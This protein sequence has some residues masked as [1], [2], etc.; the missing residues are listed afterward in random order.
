MKS[1]TIRARIEPA[2]KEEVETILSDLGLTASE[3]IQL[4]YRQIKL[5]KGLPFVVEIPNE[6]TAKTIRESKAGKGVK[7]F[8]SK[9]ELF[10]DLGL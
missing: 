10:A 8:S 5:R 1:T 2:L 6:L 4:L 3:T 9:K 7:R